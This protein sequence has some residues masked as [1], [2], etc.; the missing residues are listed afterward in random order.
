M[1]FTL[2]GGI[3]HNNFMRLTKLKPNNLATINAFWNY[4]DGP[5]KS[6]IKFMKILKDINLYENE[7]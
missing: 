3:N 5:V 1:P 2:I 6:A 4:P 7:C